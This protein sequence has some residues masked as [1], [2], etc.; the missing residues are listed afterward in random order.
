[1][2]QSGEQIKKTGYTKS[3][4]AIRCPSCSVGVNESGQN[5]G[6]LIA[7]QRV[8]C[9]IEPGKSVLIAT[10]G[11]CINDGQ[12]LPNG[13]KSDGCNQITEI[14]VEFDGRRLNI[15]EDNIRACCQRS[16]GNL[17]TLVELESG[18]VGVKDDH[19]VKPRVEKPYD[20][21]RFHEQNIDEVPF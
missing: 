18:Q 9:Q 3:D 14:K 17:F 20:P 19:T 8:I 16:Q 21:D 5:V 7:S 13:K 15:S 2:A 10:I 4:N 1:M 12:W 6:G 11:R